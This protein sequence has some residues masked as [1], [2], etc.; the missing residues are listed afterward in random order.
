MMW[1]FNKTTNQNRQENYGWQT[2][3]NVERRTT[4]TSTAVSSSS[5]PAGVGWNHPSPLTPTSP[6]D[7]SF[8]PFDEL[9]NRTEK[10][11]VEEQ[12][13]LSKEIP[14]SGLVY[15]VSFPKQKLIFFFNDRQTRK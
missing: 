3:S 10:E 14:Q 12:V 5:T 13:F 6:L 11:I 4:T 2:N 9:M 1:N 15:S 8:S 7:G